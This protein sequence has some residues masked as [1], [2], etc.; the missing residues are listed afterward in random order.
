MDNEILTRV[1]AGTP[2]G[3]LMRQYWLPALLSS[4]L[5]PGAPVRLMLLGEK[6]I[7]FRTYGGDVGIMDHRCPHRCASLFYGRVEKDGIRCTYH[8]WKFTTG[9]ACV[10]QPNVD[11]PPARIRVRTK[12]YRVVEKL[13][14]VWVY[15]GGREEPPP[16][17]EFPVLDLDSSRVSVWCEQRE[18]NYLQCLE[19]EIDTSHSGFLHMGR[20]DWDGDD[21]D[22]RAESRDDGFSINTLQNRAVRYKTIRTDAGVLAGGYRAA[23]DAQTYWRFANFALPFWTQPPPCEFG[24]EAIARAWVPMDDEHTMLFSIST[25]T[26]LSSHHP[27]AILPPPMPGLSFE[28]PRLPDT[29]DWFGRHLLVQ[30]QRNDYLIDREVQRT[31]SYSGIEGVDAQDMAIQE[32][33][34]AIVDRSLENLVGAD[35][36]IVESRRRLLAAAC[37]WRD[38]NIVPPGVDKPEAYRSWSGFIT[39]PSEEDWLDLYERARPQ[40]AEPNAKSA[41]LRYGN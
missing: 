18:C 33:M 2:M 16:L 3:D 27:N 17:P 35:L 5:K 4:E 13:G 23:G 41:E 26:F 1:G 9:G 32:S 28:L 19:A 20:V 21:S 30:N 22:T 15:M 40:G 8:G 25:D 7:A 31:Q 10:E 34:G 37:A 12:G 11:P 39:A 6:L 24:T 29:T 38:S 14:L 36:A